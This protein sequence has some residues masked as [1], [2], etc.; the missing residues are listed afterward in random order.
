M[1]DTHL[2][3]PTLVKLQKA[4]D[5]FNEVESRF[6]NMCLWHKMERAK[7]VSQMIDAGAGV[8]DAPKTILETLAHT[9]YWGMIGIKPSEAAAVLGVSIKD[10]RQLAG[11]T[12]VGS[13]SRCN[14]SIRVKSRSQF[15]NASDLCADCQNQEKEET[16]KR[17][18]EEWQRFQSEREQERQAYLASVKKPE[19]DND[20]LSA[21]ELRSMPYKEYLQ[22]QHWKDTRYAAMKRAGFSCQICNSKKPLQTHHRTYERRGFELPSDLIVLCADCHKHFH[23]R[24]N[25]D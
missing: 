1:I 17:R 25:A 13:C 14:N 2:N 3:H 7:A 22:T 23:H 24:M 20:N 21:S 11:S 4:I 19:A 16:A 10:I 15:T 18:K 5:A 9:L 8:H 6:E 12:E